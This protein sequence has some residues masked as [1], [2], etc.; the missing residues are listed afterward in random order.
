[1]KKNIILILLCFFLLLYAEIS[2][3]KSFEVLPVRI[4][5]RTNREAAALLVNGKIAL[6]LY[7]S[8]ESGESSFERIENTAGIINYILNK[9]ISIG[10]SEPVS[11]D[12][13]AS[14]FVGSIEVLSVKPAD[15]ANTYMPPLLIAY[16]W[17]NRLRWAFGAPLLSQKSIDGIIRS[18]RLRG[19]NITVRRNKWGDKADII[20]D[21][22]VVMKV[23]QSDPDL[24][25]YDSAREI[26]LSMEE[27]FS[28]GKTGDDIR[29]VIS[30]GN[31]Y[32]VRLGDSILSVIKK[33]EEL[34]YN[35]DYWTIALERAN[36]IREGF[37]A[38]PFSI[39]N[40]RSINTQYGKASWYG[41]FFHGRRAASGERYDMEEFTAAHK[42]LPFGTEVLVTRLDN[43]KSVLV[44]I[45]DRGPYIAG[46]IIDLSRAAAESIGL[47]GS[48]VTKV[49]IDILNKPDKMK[50]N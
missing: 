25:A 43:S 20:V 26:A 40:I 30:K 17:A 24:S 36:K 15:T 41:G 6:R 14:V 2:F 18:E 33:E 27:G 48:G 50:K 38:E 32:S 3:G 47:L 49:R 10:S 28:E 16:N 1:M 22:R 39:E 4:F 29:P 23:S 42:T 13:G 44:R 21:G 45:T 11:T 46:R 12:K 7:A 8:S 35:K 5:G 19:H 31:Q 34:I 37:G 9:G